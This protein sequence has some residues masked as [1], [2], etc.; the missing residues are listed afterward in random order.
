MNI[1]IDINDTL[2][3][4]LGQLEYTV[5]KYHNYGKEHLDI[6]KDPITD[7]NLFNYF[8]FKTKRDLH[9]FSFNEASLEIFG[10]APEQTDGLT[11]L[12]NRFLMD[13]EDDEEHKIIL[14]SREVNNSIPA[15]FF[16]LSKTL[17]KAKDVRFYYNYDNQWDNV[18]LMITA[19][20]ELIKLKP[21]GKKVIKVDTTYNRLV[22]GDY[23]IKG[24]ADFFS[25]ETLRNKIIENL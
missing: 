15:T 8:G 12:F 16:F 23:S 10:H 13:I 4:Y 20:P 5:N 6:D 3:W 2:R 9:D 24:L 1:A 22:D 14:T 19:N 25:N 18:D 21:K 7:F 17:N 11:T